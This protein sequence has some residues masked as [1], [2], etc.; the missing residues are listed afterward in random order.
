MI[1]KSVQ[2]TS[3]PLGLSVN[4]I[5]TLVYH[6]SMCTCGK[7]LHSGSKWIDLSV[8]QKSSMFVYVVVQIK[9]I[10]SVFMYETHLISRHGSEYMVLHGYTQWWVYGH[11][12]REALIK[13]S[14]FSLQKWT[15]KGYY[16][17][18]LLKK[19]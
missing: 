3:A 2:K 6:T 18:P 10:K 5:C 4:I 1:L 8:R 15:G 13:T 14:I 19:E 16:A 7:P 17:C 12:P 9:K 11:F